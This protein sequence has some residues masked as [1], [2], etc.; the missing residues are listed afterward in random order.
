M[1][2]KGLDGVR[3]SVAVEAARILYRREMKEYF[4]AKREAARRQG[5]IHLPSNREIHEQLLI[6][7]RSL[8]GDRHEEKL[9]EMRQ[10]AL[11]LM[12][13]LEPF[14]PRLIGSVLT[15]HIR[16][17]SDIDLH[18]HTDSLEDVLDVLHE[19]GYAPEVEVVSSRKH[20]EAQEFTHVR[21]SGPYDVEMTIYPPEWLH[22]Q[23]RCGITGGPMRRGTLAEV[24]QLLAPARESPILDTGDSARLRS[25]V[26]E[27]EVCRGVLQNHYH[28]LDVYDHTLAVV[29]GLE[30]MI[31]ENYR[32]FGPH[33]A[34]LQ[35]HIQPGLLLLAA[36]CH[37]LGKPAT[38]SLARD[39][40]IRFHGHEKVGTEMAHRIGQRL[41]LEPVVVRDLSKLV[42][43]HM[44]PVR[45][46]VEG[47]QPSRI[48]QL[49]PALGQRLP[50]LALLSLADVEACRGPAQ[51]PQRLEEQA[52]FVD[53]LLDEF[54]SGGTLAV[55][56]LPLSEA[57]L[58]DMLGELPARQ[59]GRLWHRLVGAYL[60]GEFQ[61]REEGL[62]LAAE[63][64]EEG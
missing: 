35:Q 10:Q 23:P 15:G 56:E 43:W 25:L 9:R 12:Q 50:E 20:G 47:Q 26:P 44:E 39:G 34:A 57:D 14:Q 2:R 37:D 55:P 46:P 41:G 3:H 17:G 22:T 52:E 18:V 61:S 33:A 31:R 30:E 49:F 45:I 13:L 29:R 58:E 36:I 11:T 16:Q 28:H 51:T 63:F 6:L 21:L 1:K 59:H 8:E 40:R 5:T 48:H 38:R 54:F 27:L 7:A 32:R 4:H 53:L 24:R 19:A 62:A 64:L 42:E 60:D